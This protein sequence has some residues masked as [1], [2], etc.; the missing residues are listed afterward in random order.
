MAVFELF[1]AGFN[2]LIVV[3]N[4]ISGLW[5]V[6]ATLTLCSVRAYA[7]L[8]ATISSTLLLT[9]I[10]IDRYILTCKPFNTCYSKQKAKWICIGVIVISIVASTPSLALATF[11]D[12]NMKCLQTVK[13][14]VL[15]N[16]LQMSLG[17]TY[18]VMFVVVIFCYSKVTILIRRRHKQRINNVPLTSASTS[19]HSTVSIKLSSK[20]RFVKN[21]NKIAPKHQCKGIEI[22]T[23][24]NS[25]KPASTGHET[26]L[27]LKSTIR[28]K[29]EVVR[30][31]DTEIQALEMQKIN[32]TTLI[33]FLITTIYILTWVIHWLN[34]AL[35]SRD[36]VAGR[37]VIH[38]TTYLYMI[39]CVTNPIFFIAMSSKFRR[40]AKILF[41]RIINVCRSSRQ[42]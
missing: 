21:K 4:N 35:V 29:E 12:E 39:N 33:M 6:I 15:H 2:S 28:D 19:K 26:D 22:A 34:N 32:R 40:N 1:C 8:V 13:N 16:I 31:S 20:A 25:L 23:V 3:F 10:A 30:I 14:P 9:A 17:A 7:S 18:V 36:T 37:N 24:E 11:D 38:L 42:Y 5:Y 27:D 41:T